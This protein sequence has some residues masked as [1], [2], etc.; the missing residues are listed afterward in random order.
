MLTK[1]NI[2]AALDR[3]LLERFGC[4]VGRGLVLEFSRR[5]EDSN[6][7][8]FLWATASPD[9]KRLV[10]IPQ[11]EGIIRLMY[12]TESERPKTL[13]KKSGDE[14][15]VVQLL[16][17]APEFGSLPVHCLRV[18]AWCYRYSEDVP[19]RD[20]IMRAVHTLASRAR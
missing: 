10:T 2:S 5:R 7:L 8:G 19:G 3:L 12:K 20:A 4:K 13:H 1:A 18:L 6:R 14:G 9:A 16:R 11:R 17:D 15:G